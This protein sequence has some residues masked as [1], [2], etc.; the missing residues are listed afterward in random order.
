MATVR[1]S[2]PGTY[3]A[4]ISRFWLR[5]IQTE[6]ELVVATEIVNEL[7]MR[8]DLDDASQAYFEVPTNLVEAYEKVHYPMRRLSGIEMLCGIMEDREL[9]QADVA[10]G[11]SM[12]TTTLNDLLAGRRKLNIKHIKALASFLKLRPEMFMG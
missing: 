5:P 8:T 1:G 4:L 12:A 11:A 9:T 10:R 2:I 3:L 6:E 7:A